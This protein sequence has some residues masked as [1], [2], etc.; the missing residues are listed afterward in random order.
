MSLKLLLSAAA[1]LVASGAVIAV[2]A[3][4]GDTDDPGTIVV[5]VE[6]EPPGS[7]G[8]FAVTGVPSCAYTDE[9]PAEPCIPAGG[10]L[11]VT[12]LEPGTYTTTMV[13]P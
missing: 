6:T 12:D 7:A 4:G 10:T 3:A 8:T 13:D 9:G 1:L 11:V 2:V 5:A